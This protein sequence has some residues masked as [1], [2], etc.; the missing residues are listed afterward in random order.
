MKQ[1]WSR[2][3]AIVQIKKRRLGEGSL[4][5]E[6]VRRAP[7]ALRMY[8]YTTIGPSKPVGHI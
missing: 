2:R 4:G 8:E 3:A 6:Y 1:F 7:M 5:S